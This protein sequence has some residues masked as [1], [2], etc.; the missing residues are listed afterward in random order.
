MMAVG[1]CEAIHPR[2]VLNFSQI[3]E[4]QSLRRLEFAFVAGFILTQA[5]KGYLNLKYYLEKPGFET[6]CNIVAKT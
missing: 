6:V 1:A 4:I 2:S 3:L 5:F